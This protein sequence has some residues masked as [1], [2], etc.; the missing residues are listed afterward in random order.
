MIRLI[1]IV[2]LFSFV[3]C[4]KNVPAAGLP[5]ITDQG[6]NTFGFKLNGN[7]WI[8]YYDC[9][10]FT[11]PTSALI[12]LVYRDTSGNYT[13]P[14]GFDLRAQRV[15]TNSTDYFE[16][17]PRFSLSPYPTYISHTGN[18]FDSLEI[19]FKR[20]FCCDTYSA[21]SNYSPG[22]VNVTKLDTANKIMSGTFSFNLYT[23]IGQVL[24]S[25][26]ITDGRFDLKFDGSICY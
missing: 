25:V 1:L 19:T 8:P 10:L 24:D 22:F 23:Y 15:S 14:L 26:V 7:T 4:K 2:C 17:K 20:G 16:M 12:F 3:Q 6:K 18:M 11:G 9:G 13:W 21:F 5:A